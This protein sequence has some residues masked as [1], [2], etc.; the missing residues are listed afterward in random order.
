M[1]RR[2]D[3]FI[4]GFPKCGTTSLYEYLK[5]HP[6]V[7]MSPAKEPRYFADPETDGSAGHDLAYPA[8]EQRY[9][10]LFAEAREEQRVGEAT[11]GYVYSDQA[12]ARIKAFEPEARVIVMVRE[13]VAMMQSLH[14]QRLEEGWEPPASFDQALAP[15]PVGHRQYYLDRAAYARYLPAWS[16]AL[17]HERVHFIVMEDLVAD[18]HGTF[19]RVLEFL[20]I[21]QGYTPQFVAHN[22]RWATR[23]PLL[24]RAARSRFPQWMIRRAL[25]ALIGEARVKSG[26]R[27]LRHSGLGRTGSRSALVSPALRAD[28]QRELAP[29]VAKLSE[30]LGRDLVSLWWPSS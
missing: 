7:F 25:P 24:R 3:F 14:S 15:E 8:D 30:M 11:T 23:F 17:G 5:G 12:P 9:L 6:D 1:S 29:D 18:P 2:P 4:V 27:R 16:V 20:D 13:P 26:V 22:T 10:N 28:L 19:R 21:D